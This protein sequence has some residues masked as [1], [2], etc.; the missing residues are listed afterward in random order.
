MKIDYEILYRQ[1]GEKKSR[2]IEIDFVPNDRHR[3]ARNIQQLIFDMQLKWDEIKSTE[4]QLQSLEIESKEFKKT[5]EEYK[6][7]IKNLQKDIQKIGYDGII[8]RR[9]NLVLSI[10]EDNGIRED[11]EIRQYKFW[12][13][14]V[15]P[16]DINNLI[17]AAINKD[18]SKKKAM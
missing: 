13:S 15:E 16:I 9:I 4:I 5:A 14:C 17:E 2:I 12:D 1:K 3:E 10:L 18:L 11:D 6:T 7:K 8:E